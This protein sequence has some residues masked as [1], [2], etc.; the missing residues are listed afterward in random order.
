MNLR[1]WLFPAE[2][3]GFVGKRW[4]MISLRTLHLLGVAGAGA[5][6]LGATPAQGLTFYLHLMLS[7]G[8]LMAALE[9]WSHGV[10]LLQ[11]KGLA[12]VI[13]LLLLWSILLWP[14]LS[15][16]LFVII[17][18]ISGVISHAPGYIRYYSPWHRRRLH[19]P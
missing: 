16:P 4:L 18:L 9:I 14:S 6:F 15:V 2:S 1:S 13:K 3:R 7:T 19:H 11:L 10:W 12:V 5:L 17:I 8:V